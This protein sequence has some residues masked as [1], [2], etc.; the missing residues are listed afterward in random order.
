MPSCWVWWDNS[1]WPA[2]DKINFIF[3]HTSQSRHTAVVRCLKNT[4][5]RHW[6]VAHEFKLTQWDI[7]CLLWVQTLLKVCSTFGTY[8]LYIQYHV[9]LDHVTMSQYFLVIQTALSC[10]CVQADS[11]FVPSQWE[12]SLQSNAVSHW[13]GAHLESTL[14]PW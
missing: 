11:S 7:G 2:K 14:R 3:C 8:V 6:I 5:N 13:L 9:T 4:N 1:G 10:L 12:T